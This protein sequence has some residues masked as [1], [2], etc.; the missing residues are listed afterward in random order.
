MT[1]VERVDDIINNRVHETLCKNC[2]EPADVDKLILIAYY[3][4]RE[5]ATRKVCD[6]YNELID[7]ML[8]RAEQSR[9]HKL[10]HDIIGEKH[11]VYESDYS[12]TVHEAFGNDPADI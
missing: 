9:Y 12:G 4:G 2:K 1:I 11:Y 6:D 7:E 3:L 8:K 5:D 10:A